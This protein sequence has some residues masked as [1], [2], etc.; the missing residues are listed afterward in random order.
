MP[1]K[2]AVGRE[3]LRGSG[4]RAAGRFTTAK[5]EP[6]VGR[7]RERPG[8]PKR[9]RSLRESTVSVRRAVVRRGGVPCA[10]SLPR[11]GSRRRWSQSRPRRAAAVGTSGA[12][13]AVGLARGR[14]TGR[15]RL[16]Q[17]GGG[18]SAP[19]GGGDANRSAP[20]WG[21]PW[22]VRAMGSRR[23]VGSGR[24]VGG[25]SVLARGRWSQPWARAS[26]PRGPAAPCRRACPTRTR[27]SGAAPAVG[28]P[29]R[30]G[31]SRP[32]MPPA[33]AGG[34]RRACG[35]AGGWALLGARACTG[36]R[37][38]PGRARSAAARAAALW[39]SAASRPLAP[40]PRPGRQG[41]AQR[42]P[43]SGRAPG[44]YDVGAISGT[45]GPSRSRPRAGWPSQRG[46]W[47]GA[48]RPGARQA[49]AADHRCGGRSRG[50]ARRP[51][52]ALRTL[53]QP[54]CP[55]ARGRHATSHMG[56]RPPWPRAPVQRPGA[57]P[58]SSRLGGMPRVC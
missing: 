5:Q 6:P 3:A 15:C 17:A 8:R 39:G 7:A 18:S 35:V 56:G 46:W 9:Q 34:A 4:Q 33:G 1:V 31:A 26:S 16:P 53:W 27:R 29:A 57:V 28:M 37:W 24:P 55:P 51:V 21:R 49:S 54:G 38:R 22:G 14:P 50:P 12:R 45:S 19:T 44:A 11:G 30:L 41:C 36:G 2:V 10:A 47:P 25:R 13:R 43:W 40:S 42:S 23:G 32:S 20:P 58:R 48:T 52:R